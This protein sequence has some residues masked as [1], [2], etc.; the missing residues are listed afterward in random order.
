MIK[1][2]KHSVIKSFTVAVFI[3]ALALPYGLQLLHRCNAHGHDLE[4][5]LGDHSFNEAELC[6]S[7]CK[8]VITINYLRPDFFEF[9][10]I[11]ELNFETR[12]N[13]RNHLHYTHTGAF[14]LLRAP[15]KA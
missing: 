9:E 14:K 7:L 6:C 13:I 12:F 1:V 15:P 3:A 8:T 4:L 5:N 2:M 11:D 10:L